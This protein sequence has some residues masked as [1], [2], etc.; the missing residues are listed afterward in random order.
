[1]DCGRVQLSELL[2]VPLCWLKLRQERGMVVDKLITAVV[3]SHVV[4]EL[5]SCLFAQ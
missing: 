1:M 2:Q 4:N 5:W 3:Y